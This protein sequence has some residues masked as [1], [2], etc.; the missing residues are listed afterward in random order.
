MTLDFG[1]IIACAH[2]GDD[3]FDEDSDEAALAEHLALVH[4]SVSSDVF[5]S[6]FSFSII[7]FSL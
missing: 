1:S 6:N 5:N 7:E 4:N 2:V 3:S